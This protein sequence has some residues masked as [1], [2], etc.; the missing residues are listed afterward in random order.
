LYQGRFESFPIER[1]EHLLGIS[2][3]LVEYWEQG[4]RIPGPLACRLLE[5]IAA[6]PKSMVKRRPRTTGTAE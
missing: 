5:C 1:D 2:A 4:R 3:K 6:Y